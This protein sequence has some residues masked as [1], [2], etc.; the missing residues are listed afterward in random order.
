MPIPVV[1]ISLGFMYLYTHFSHPIAK[2]PYNNNQTNKSFMCVTT[3]LQKIF[4][5]VLCRD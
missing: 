3:P 2:E 1:Y 5:D 4:L